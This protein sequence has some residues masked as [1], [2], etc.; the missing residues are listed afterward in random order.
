[1]FID[2]HDSQGLFNCYINIFMIQQTSN[3]TQIRALARLAFMLSHVKRDGDSLCES[4]ET[5]HADFESR[6]ESSSRVMH[7]YLCAC[8]SKHDA[9]LREF[10]GKTGFVRTKLSFHDCRVLNR[11]F[12]TL[13]FQFRYDKKTTRGDNAKSQGRKKKKS[14]KKTVIR[15]QSKRSSVS[16]CRPSKKM[17]V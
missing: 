4:H 12:K 2:N 10:L 5:V 8:M 1:M 13:S 7:M 17:K 6:K 15:V 14:K 9:Y 16:R 3:R 11:G